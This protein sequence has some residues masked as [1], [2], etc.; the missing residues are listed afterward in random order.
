MAAAGRGRWGAAC[1]AALLIVHQALAT[2][3]APTHS[4]THSPHTP[5]SPTHSPEEHNASASGSDSASSCVHH[6]GGIQYDPQDAPN[7][8]LFIFFCVTVG[9]FIKI[10]QMYFLTFLRR[11]PYTVLLFLVGFAM[12]WGSRAGDD[13]GGA[14]GHATRGMIRLDPH[15]VLHIFLP[16]L[17]FESAFAMEHYV[18]KKCLPQALM[19]AF[20]GVLIASGVTG[21]LLKYWYD[22]YDWGWAL[23]FMFGSMVS[24]TDPVAVVALLAELGAP[25][26]LSTCIEAES[27]M[28]DG[29]AFVVFLIFKE[30]AAFG[31]TALSHG[32]VWVKALRLALG[33]PACGLAFGIGLTQLMLRFVMNE[34]VIEIPMTIATAYITFWTAEMT[35]Y[36]TSGV[37]AVVTLGI[38]MGSPYGAKHLSPEIEESM[39]HVWHFL[40]H[41]ANTV[42]FVLSGAVTMNLIHA[43][44]ISGRDWANLVILYVTVHITRGITVVSLWPFLSRFGYPMSW[45]RGVILWFGGLRGAIGLVLALIVSHEDCIPLDDRNRITFLTAG[46]V[47]MTII[48]NGYLAGPLYQGIGLAALPSGHMTTL[49]LSVDLMESHAENFLDKLAR[50]PW[51]DANLEGTMYRELEMLKM[52]RGHLAGIKRKSTKEDKL[53]QERD[54]FSEKLRDLVVR[55]FRRTYGDKEDG[56]SKSSEEARQLL[57]VRYL[58]PVFLVATRQLVCKEFV[59]QCTHQRMCP[60]R[61]KAK[62]GK[63]PQSPGSPGTY[64]DH[65]VRHYWYRFTLNRL[66]HTR[67]LDRSHKTGEESPQSPGPETQVAKRRDSVI[68]VDTRRQQ[69][70]R[71]AVDVG[72]VQKV[73]DPSKL[74]RSRAEYDRIPGEPGE[75]IISNVQELKYDA[76]LDEEERYHRAEEKMQDHKNLLNEVPWYPN[77][78]PVTKT[79]EAWGCCQATGLHADGFHVTEL[80]YL[81]LQDEIREDVRR[82]ILQGVKAK[83][84]TWLE[85]RLID[86]R[87][88]GL[89]MEAVMYVE[90]EDRITHGGTRRYDLEAEWARLKE[91][92]AIAPLNIKYIMVSR[93]PPSLESDGTIA[94]MTHTVRKRS[95]LPADVEKLVKEDIPELRF[96]DVRPGQWVYLHLPPPE[97]EDEPE[98]WPEEVWCVGVVHSRDLGEFGSNGHVRLRLQPDGGAPEWLFSRYTESIMVDVPQTHWDSDAHPCLVQSCT[99]FGM[100]GFKFKETMVTEVLAKSSAEEAGL[101]PRQRFLV[102][103]KKPARSEE[104]VRKGLSAAQHV[105]CYLTKRPREALCWGKPKSRTGGANRVLAES[106]LGRGHSAIA[107]VPRLSDSLDFELQQGCVAEG[108]KTVTFVDRSSGYPRWVTVSPDISSDP[109]VD[110]DNSMQTDSQ[111]KAVFLERCTDHQLGDPTPDASFFHRD[112][113]HLLREGMTAEEK[114][115]WR[116]GYM[117]ESGVC[118]TRLKPAGEG[119]KK[120]IDT[121]DQRIVEIVYDVP[122]LDNA[123]FIAKQRMWGRLQVSVAAVRKD[124]QATLEGALGITFYGHTARVASVTKGSPADEHG[125]RRGMVLTQLNK[126]FFTGIQSNVLGDK[127][128]RH[129]PKYV[130]VGSG[131]TASFT[132]MDTAEGGG[133]DAELEE[134]G[135]LLANTQVDAFTWYAWEQRDRDPGDPNPHSSASGDHSAR[136]GTLFLLST[137]WRRGQ[138]RLDKRSADRGMNVISCRLHHKY[139]VFQSVQYPDYFLVGH[140]GMIVAEHAPED[141]ADFESFMD[142][143]SFKVIARP[144]DYLSGRGGPVWTRLEKCLQRCCGATVARRLRTWWYL[145]DLHKL[146]NCLLFFRAAH[147]EVWKNVSQ[148]WGE[149]VDASSGSRFSNL[150]TGWAI[151]SPNDCYGRIGYIRAKHFRIE[152]NQQLK[153]L[154]KAVMNT[155]IYSLPD[156]QSDML[157]NI[158]A[159]Q[160]GEH[161]SSK[162]V[163]V[164]DEFQLVSDPGAAGFNHEKEA[165]ERAYAEG[166]HVLRSLNL[167][168]SANGVYRIFSHRLLNTTLR[169]TLQS[170]AHNGLLTPADMERVDLCIKKSTRTLHTQKD[171]LVNLLG[172]FGSRFIPSFTQVDMDHRDSFTFPP[173]VIPHYAVPTWHKLE[174][175][176]HEVNNNTL[177]NRDAMHEIQFISQLQAMEQRHDR[178]ISGEYVDQ[179]AVELHELGPDG[180]PPGSPMTPTTKERSARRFLATLQSGES[181]R[182]AEGARRVGWVMRVYPGD[183]AKPGRVTVRFDGGPEARARNLHISKSTRA[184][185]DVRK[186]ELRPYRRTNRGHSVAWYR[187]KCAAER[188]QYR[189][190]VD[191]VRRALWLRRHRLF[192]EPE[193]HKLLCTKELRQKQI[194]GGI[195]YGDLL[196]ASSD[197]QRRKLLQFRGYGSWWGAAPLTA[198]DRIKD[199]LYIHVVD[200]SGVFKPYPNFAALTRDGNPWIPSAKRHFTVLSAHQGPFEVVYRVYTDGRDPRHERLSMMPFLTEGDNFYVRRERYL[201]S[202]H[203]YQ[204]QKWAFPPDKNTSNHRDMLLAAA[205]TAEA[206]MLGRLREDA[207]EDRL[208]IDLL[209]E[210]LRRVALATGAVKWY[211]AKGFQGTHGWE[212]GSVGV[213]LEALRCKFGVQGAAPVG[214]IVSVEAR[215]DAIVDY[216]QTV[217]FPETEERW[218]NDPHSDTRYD[219]INVWHRDPDGSMT[220]LCVHIVEVDPD[221]NGNWIGVERIELEVGI[222]GQSEEAL[223]FTGFYLPSTELVG[224]VP[225]WRSVA[226]AKQG[227]GETFLYLAEV[228]DL[229]GA[230]DVWHIASEANTRDESKIFVR[231]FVPFTEAMQPLFDRAPELGWTPLSRGTPGDTRLGVKGVAQWSHFTDSTGEKF[232]VV[233]SMIPHRT[234]WRGLCGSD[235]PGVPVRL[236]R[237]GADPDEGEWE[238]EV[239]RVDPMAQTA[240]ILWRRGDEGGPPQ[241]LIPKREEE[242]T[243]EWWETGARPHIKYRWTHG[244]WTNDLNCPTLINMEMARRHLHEEAVEQGGA[245]ARASGLGPVCGIRTAGPGISSSHTRFGAARAELLST[246]QSFAPWPKA[247]TAEGSKYALNYGGEWVNGRVRGGMWHR[248]ELVAVVAGESEGDKERSEFLRLRS[249]EPGSAKYDLPNKFQPETSMVPDGET[250]LRPDEAYM[251]L[252]A[253]IAAGAE[254]IFE[255]DM[256]LDPTGVRT[257]GDDVPGLTLAG[258]VIYGLGVDRL[259]EGN[260]KRAGIELSHKTGGTSMWCR[261]VVTMIVEGKADGREYEEARKV[262]SKKNPRNTHASVRRPTAGGDGASP[263]HDGGHVAVHRKGDP[264]RPYAQDETY[265]IWHSEVVTDAAHNAIQGILN[266]WRE[267]EDR[268]RREGGFPAA[269]RELSRVITLQVRTEWDLEL[270]YFPVFF[271]HSDSVYADPAALS[272]SA[273]VRDRRGSLKRTGSSIF[274]TTAQAATPVGVAAAHRKRACRQDVAALKYWAA[275]HPSV[276]IPEL[277]EKGD[278]LYGS[279]LSDV[280]S[281]IRSL[282]DRNALARSPA[283][284][285]GYRGELHGPTS[286]RA[287]RGSQGRIKTEDSPTFAPIGNVKSTA[288]ITSGVYRPISGQVSLKSQE[289]DAKGPMMRS[290]G[291]SPGACTPTEPYDA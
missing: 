232:Q 128:R 61:R 32:E 222:E 45:K 150:P 132:V 227:K 126:R 66:A 171:A 2:A 204:T 130:A 95:L 97:A 19:L 273:A 162:L 219:M 142:R 220:E 48:V 167:F 59:A 69:L 223:Q 258:P 133:G 230:M 210:P 24:A 21:V 14:L 68:I 179:S 240:R 174:E 134:A 4:P 208:D 225:V 127:L 290:P 249:L 76:P 203:F 83:Y 37:L 9:S 160:R 6:A 195:A 182:E 15:L 247:G 87:T 170:C 13:D 216:V 77:F 82:I 149:L 187:F 12:E 138:D 38:Y 44:G 111:R 117:T 233:A 270:Q 114:A 145:S 141:S 17:L 197:A 131:F 286:P 146:I 166:D 81:P 56:G 22:T 217:S 209:K 55:W 242:V 266:D 27:L 272:T 250:T 243:K 60:V 112:S 5:G 284:F 28:N 206:A 161:Y 252:A 188:V 57:Q 52:G 238:A 275:Y 226:N 207:E 118:Y 287:R 211:Q 35:E 42:L 277:E 23:S 199:L 85:E 264:F 237:P 63:E 267:Q 107:A 190:V 180:V 221:G 261:H 154:A 213:M 113:M 18:L 49:K 51:W 72:Y 100:D 274:R 246:V 239:T 86:A 144:S 65:D 34:P 152:R 268:M 235:P 1:A 90:D 125:V 281:E 283:V 92:A 116:K 88:F 228:G 105:R 99:L 67:F 196:H 20:P 181:V 79:V 75:V 191:R 33:G 11:I 115:I 201:S 173:V 183:A 30:F 175:I 96:D 119:K 39:E 137:H 205:S 260:A 151:V 124:K 159:A 156:T 153:P 172:L 245:V 282:H 168:G 129:F 288:S 280:R 155:H 26:A 244:A 135:Q 122:S 278:N 184:I 269:D 121:D 98:P 62:E 163:L 229:E 31:G 50:K 36:A 25:K 78:R 177:I 73:L 189:T 255:I 7:I 176:Q 120:V 104:D 8:L 157:D 198:V 276:D 123:I 202:E 263:E 236:R 54:E 158:Y 147:E 259:E 139:S 215:G 43:G 169:E 10:T 212:M 64:W 108:L 248:V 200:Q 16:P 262:L 58:Q 70:F 106:G 257:E 148:Q 71:D 136:A 29:S 218:R 80:H 241:D 53:A 253:W 165:L 291:A 194:Q 102:V 265:P 41:V 224:G 91:Q 164:G 84:K 285:V 234:T 40:G 109:A 185:L 143:A 192:P 214:D 93:A 110:P 140:A 289:D 256:S 103:D 46:L 3:P 74:P 231:C 251:D 94:T 178:E 47:A 193:I 89:L 271:D 101:R 186:L 279:L 254:R